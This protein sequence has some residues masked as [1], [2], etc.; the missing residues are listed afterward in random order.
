MGPD[1][2]A[3]VEDRLIADLQHYL[4]SNSGLDHPSLVFD[5][6]ESCVEGHRSDW[7]DGKIEN[8]SGVIVRDRSQNLVADGW[9]EFI[10][11]AT[12][13]EVFWWYLG[14]GTTYEFPAK[15]DNRIP[16]HVWERLGPNER[17]L[18]DEFSPPRK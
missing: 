6:S 8:F 13:L 14:C 12:G 3:F 16:L 10:E 11:T 17:S 9:M 5:W 4:P 2:R 7:M 1:L 18:W 15:K